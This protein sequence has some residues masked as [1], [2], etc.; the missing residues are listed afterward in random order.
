MTATE[1]LSSDSDSNKDRQPATTTIITSVPQD[2]V[3]I[4]LLHPEKNETQQ[5]QQQAASS[6]VQRIL[7]EQCV[8]L[9][10]PSL[11]LVTASQRHGL[12][13]ASRLAAADAEPTDFDTAGRVRIPTPDAANR[14]AAA[15]T[16]CGTPLPDQADDLLR[17]LTHRI[18]AYLDNHSPWQEAVQV[19]FASDKDTTQEPR[20]RLTQLLD[21]NQLTYASREPAINVYQ[22]GGACFLPPRR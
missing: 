22:T 21:H 16:C 14:A 7:Q 19:L 15:G 1:E 18:F 8:V 6:L 10:S 20:I 3:E 11:D 13:Q 9:L 4:S 2:W 17:A 5:Q 12:C